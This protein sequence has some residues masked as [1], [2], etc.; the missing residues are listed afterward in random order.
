MDRLAGD[1][2]A[3]DDELHP[4]DGDGAWVETVWFSWAV[5]TRALMGYV[6]VIFRPVLGTVEGGA[7]VYDHSGE[8]PWEL[9]AF[10]FHDPMPMQRDVDLRNAEL[11]NG[12]TIRCD[13]P[14]TA[15]RVAYNGDRVTVD[16]RFDAVARP[17][18]SRSADGR[19]G[20]IDQMGSVTGDMVL[21]G[22]RSA[23]DCVAMRDRGW[24][25]RTYRR[26]TRYGYAY[27]AADGWEP[28]RVSAD[29]FLAVTSHRDG[30]D[31]VVKG[32]LQQG[33]VWAPLVAGERRVVRDGAGRPTAVSV[34]AVDDLGRS[35]HAVGDV[36]SRHAFTPYRR[37]VTWDSLVRWRWATHLGWGEDQD[38]W[39]VDA[40]RKAHVATR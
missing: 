29:C 4:H 34:D 22:E 25:P 5:P 23:V 14:G 35:L 27:A 33:A 40:W 16:L 28:G 2:T 32:F 7:L 15:Y 21:A 10:E 24:G 39:H 12:V 17:L 1:V 18:V 11:S 8:L 36:A 3:L 6:Y 38:V 26:D 13:A 19:C 37:L 20:H 31:R 30:A 9:P